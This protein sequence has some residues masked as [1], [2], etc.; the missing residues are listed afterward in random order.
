M[1]TFLS[2][3]LGAIF[4]ILIALLF[5]RDCEDKKPESYEA[6][7]KVVDANTDK[8][9]KGARV[10]IKTDDEACRKATLTTDRRGECTFEYS[11]PECT[12][13]VAVASKDGY[14]DGKSEDVQLS[15]FQDDVLVIPLEKKDL[16]EEAREVGQQGKLKITLLWDETEADLDLHVIE[17]NGNEIYWENKTDSRTT[18]E[19]D[20]DWNPKNEESWDR[21]VAENVFWKRPPRGN[22]QVRVVYYL[23]EN[24]EA[25]TSGPPAVCNV[26]IF[27]D[28]EEPEKFE[29]L[30]LSGPGDEVQVT[31][32]TYN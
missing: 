31:T 19:L 6:T 10:V 3:L 22:Y 4:A 24:S 26:I 11:D 21:P 18:G 7:I 9:I 25:D 8:P 15:Y 1:R 12:L 28:N 27:K 20:F 14:E 32:Y 5:L 16:E 2:I 13:L 23:D 30:R 17:P 29:N